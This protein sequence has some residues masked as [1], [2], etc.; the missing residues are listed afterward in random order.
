MRLRRRARLPEVQGDHDPGHQG[1][2]RDPSRVLGRHRLRGSGDDA[3][4]PV[5]P[6]G[7]AGSRAGDKVRGLR[8]AGQGEDQLQVVASFNGHLPE[9]DRDRVQRQDAP[10][11]L[12]RGVPQGRDPGRRQQDQ[13]RGRPVLQQV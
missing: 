11:G 4:Q 7:E 3:G 5:H 6:A 1:G 2:S 13:G 8:T 12:R 10:E 9:R